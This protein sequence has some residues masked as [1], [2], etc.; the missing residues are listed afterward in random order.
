MTLPVT[1]QVLASEEHSALAASEHSPFMPSAH[2][3][4]AAGA[5]VSVTS[6]D[7]DLQATAAPARARVMRILFMFVIRFLLDLDHPRQAT[8]AKGL[9]TRALRGLSSI[10]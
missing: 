7:C 3:V 4:V 5:E 8:A 2:S 6:V 10:G 1:G 9:S